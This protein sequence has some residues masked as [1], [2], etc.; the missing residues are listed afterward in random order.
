MM[1][2]ISALQLLQ[3]AAGIPGRAG[4]LQNDL[5]TVRRSRLRDY[6]GHE[7]PVRL[8]FEHNLGEQH[9]LRRRRGGTMRH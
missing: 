5:R 9:Y 2:W 1:A 7:R 6:H 8:L 3:W 4:V